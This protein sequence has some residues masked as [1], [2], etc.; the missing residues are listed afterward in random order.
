LSHQSLN[1]LPVNKFWLCPSHPI[2]AVLERVFI[3]DEVQAKRKKLKQMYQPSD[4]RDDTYAG[5]VWVLAPG[6]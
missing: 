3:R 4:R 5:G 6:E 2:P 1:E